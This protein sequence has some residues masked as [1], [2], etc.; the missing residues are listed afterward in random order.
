MRQD[1]TLLGVVMML[2]F[3]VVA[4]VI[5][6]S[7]KLA[8]QTIAT[9]QVTTARYIVQAALLVPVMLVMG[10][11]FRM[12][13]Y[14]WGLTFVRAAL[15]VAATFSFVAAVRVMPIA[16]ALAIAFVEPFIL[17]LMGWFF[18]A[19]QV[20]PRRLIASAI[21]FLGALFVIQPSFSQFGPVA[22]FPLLTAVF[23][24]LY[25]II[26]RKLTRDTHPVT[27]QT[28]TALAAIVLCTPVLWLAEGSDITSLDPSWPQ[29]VVWV[30]LFGV[31]AAATV[32]HLFITFALRYAPSATIA[33]LQYLEIVVAA[34][35]GY[36]VFGDFPDRLTWIGIGIIVSAGL[37]IVLRERGLS[38]QPAAATP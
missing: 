26:T 11:S 31:G 24:A 28:T 19:E 17:M 1:R 25:L 7:A 2:G 6:A 35:L 12:D 16:D 32:S 15:S 33:P 23:F 8:V 30:F 20:G 10:Q 29:G 9:G 37:Y 5:D 13:R 14:R 21:G 18:F 36:L 22:F 4:P 34:L 27:L 38:R 3:C